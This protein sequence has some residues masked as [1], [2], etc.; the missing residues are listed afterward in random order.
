MRQTN[1]VP[2]S[3]A[4]QSVLAVTLLSLAGSPVMA[5]GP[6]RVATAVKPEPQPAQTF[7]CEGLKLPELKAAVAASQGMLD[8]LWLKTKAGYFAAYTLPGMRHNP[9]DLK[10]LPPDS[11]PR[12]GLAQARA[13]TCALEQIA[14]DRFV[15][16]FITPFYRFFEAKAGWSAPLRNGLMMEVEVTGSGA[17]L[18]ARDRWPEAAILQRELNARPANEKKIPRLTRWAEP[19]PGCTRHKRWNGRDCIRRRR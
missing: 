11:G 16:R 6:N 8:A 17:A 14:S 5:E 13:P 9:F 15:V 10:P 2:Y 7:A 18:V 3:L 1:T 19:V 4:K 12:D